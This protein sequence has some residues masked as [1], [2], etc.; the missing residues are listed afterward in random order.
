[1]IAA[2]SRAVNQGEKRRPVLAGAAVAVLG[3]AAATG[4][5]YGLKQVA[6][7]VSLSVVYL[8]AVLLVSAYWGLALGLATSILSAA[9]STSST[10]RPWAASR[11]PT[12]ATGSLWPR[13]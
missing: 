3:V 9:R 8:P 2:S 11:S 4:A 5:I 6:P 1:M 12:A 10:S 7:V 13:S